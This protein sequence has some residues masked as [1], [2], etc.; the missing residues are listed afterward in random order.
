MAPLFPRHHARNPSEHISIL[1][2]EIM[3]RRPFMTLHPPPST[4]A[5]CRMGGAA[6]TLLALAVVPAHADDGSALRILKTMSDYMAG[7]KNL[8]VR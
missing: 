3:R 8:S 6:A 1:T 4:W 5:I 2:D 7:Q